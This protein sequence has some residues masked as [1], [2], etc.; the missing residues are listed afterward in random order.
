MSLHYSNPPPPA[1]L[2]PP[3][4]AKHQTSTKNSKTPPP[5]EQ[6]EIQSPLSVKREVKAEENDTLKSQRSLQFWGLAGK[7]SIL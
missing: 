2:L 1:F 5:H 6:T 4:D 7:Y 3:K